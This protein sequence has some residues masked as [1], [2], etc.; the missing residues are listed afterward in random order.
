MPRD[1][2]LIALHCLCS[3]PRL[4]TTSARNQGQSGEPFINLKYNLIYHTTLRGRLSQRRNY[5]IYLS[6][7]ID[8]QE[9]AKS[10][11]LNPITII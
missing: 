1:K 9:T 3:M 6:T 5:V 4:Y 11:P 2:S 7:A 8:G 10:L